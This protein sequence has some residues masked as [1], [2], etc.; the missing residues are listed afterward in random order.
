MQAK[1]D[2]EVYR[3]SVQKLTEVV[4]VVVL[5]VLPQLEAAAAA[6]VLL[7]TF[8]LLLAQTHLAAAV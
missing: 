1:V 8:K 2:L 4:A 7:T 6:V 3:R 5:R